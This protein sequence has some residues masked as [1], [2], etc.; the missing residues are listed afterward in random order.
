MKAIRFHQH[1]GAEVL[2]YEDSPA[3]EAGPGEAIVQIEAI[4]LNQLSTHLDGHGSSG[5]GGG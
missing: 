4:G 1:G 2:V 3:P 5:I